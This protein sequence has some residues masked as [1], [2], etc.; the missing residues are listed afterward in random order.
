MI[1]SKRF[2]LPNDPVQI[3][4]K[5]YDQFIKS[6]GNLCKRKNP[7]LTG[8][9]SKEKGKILSLDI[10]SRTLK[11]ALFCLSKD[12]PELLQYDIK[13]LGSSDSE[14]NNKAILDFI[15]NFIT[16]NSILDKD[17]IINAQD[18]DSVIMKRISLPN[19]PQ[20]EMEEAIKWEIKGDAPFDLEQAQIDWQIIGEYTDKDGAKRKDIMVGCVKNDF[21]DKYAKPIKEAGLNVVDIKLM[22][23]NFSYIFS[24]VLEKLEIPKSGTASVLDIG[25]TFST[26]LIYKECKL[27]FLRNLPFSSDQ[28]TMG[29]S[30]TLVSDAGKIELTT[31]KAEE[32]K[33]EFGIPRDPEEVLKDGIKGSQIISLMRPALE[34]LISEINRSINYYVSK[35]EDEF[36]QN[37]FLTGG[38]SNLKGLDVYLQNELKCNVRKLSLTNIIATKQNID[39]DARNKGMAQLNNLTGAAIGAGKSPSF[40]PKEYKTEKAEAL[41][42]MSLRVIGVVLGVVFLFSLVVVRS[43]VNDYKNRLKNA[44]L[45]LEAIGAISDLNNKVASKLTLVEQIERDKMPPDWVLKELSNITPPSC[46]LESLEINQEKNLLILNGYVVTAPQNLEG[47][48][49]GFMEKLEASPFFNATSLSSSSKAS[50]DGKDVLKFEIRSVLA[51]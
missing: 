39:K 8:I 7:E 6:Y 3:I 45:H 46:L 12:M 17:I 21:I 26:F 35:F 10:G 33:I 38:G 2:Q 22:P 27:S 36:P 50:Y 25:A 51:R 37:L 29:M 42:K 20:R 41:Q 11:I 19:M 23:F 44:R 15:N 18:L 43:E 14:D 40:L 5:L 47:D 4:T 9:F 32:M 30:G 28:L 16:V 31:Q 49:M 34:R 48:L 1:S 13:E 24:Y